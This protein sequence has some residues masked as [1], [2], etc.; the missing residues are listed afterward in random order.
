MSKERGTFKLE[1]NNGVHVIVGNNYKPWWQHALEYV[2]YNCGDREAI[3]RDGWRYEH[4]A[5]VIKSV[6]YSNQQFYDDGGL[7]Y[8]EWS[9]YQEVVNEV[10]ERDGLAPV[11]VEKIIF[12]D[13]PVYKAVLTKKLK[14]Y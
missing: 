9:A 3:S 5:D 14:E 1:L 6:S 11:D 13:A 2:Y 7:K 10:C 12:D 4:V 8:C